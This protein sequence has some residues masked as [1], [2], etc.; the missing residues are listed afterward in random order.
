[1]T[2]KH[3]E[4]TPRT[5]TVEL[6]QTR[7]GDWAPA[8]LPRRRPVDRAV[9]VWLRQCVHPARLRTSQDGLSATQRRRTPRPGVRET[10]P[11]GRSLMGARLHRSVAPRGSSPG[12]R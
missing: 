7:G 1:M 9:R 4:I 8:P 12:P 5:R 3:A 10:G 2:R 6:V 11:F